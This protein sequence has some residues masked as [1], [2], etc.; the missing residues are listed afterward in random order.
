MINEPKLLMCQY[1]KG[2]DVHYFPGTICCDNPECSI[3]DTFDGFVGNWI[4]VKDRLSPVHEWVLAYPTQL[5]GVSMAWRLESGKYLS[6]LNDYWWQ[7]P[8]HW[9]PLPEP[10]EVNNA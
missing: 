1:C 6:L 10:P 8:T 7:P 5:M 3:G 4:S 9:M 2:F